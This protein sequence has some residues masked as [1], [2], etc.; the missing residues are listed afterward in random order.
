SATIVAAALRAYG[1]I[2][3]A[4]AS[5]PAAARSCHWAVSR[6]PA[7][8]TFASHDGGGPSPLARYERTIA[9]R[10]VEASSSALM[11]TQNGTITTTATIATMIV[12]ASARLPPTRFCTDRSSGHV[13]TTIAVA[14]ISA[15]MKGSNVHRLP[16]ISRPMI[17]TVRVVRV[18]SG[19]ALEFMA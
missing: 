18:M 10:L 16:T 13:A 2:V 8:G 4:K 14:Q 15:P 7:N 1:R 6:S 12:V 3:S 11:A 9:M 17:S 19:D 5:G